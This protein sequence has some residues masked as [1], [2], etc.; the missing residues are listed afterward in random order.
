MFLQNRIL[1][2]TKNLLATSGQ[3]GPSINHHA[4]IYLNFWHH[5][6]PLRLK[7]NPVQCNYPTTIQIDSNPLKISDAIQVPCSNDRELAIFY[8]NRVEGILY[9]VSL[10]SWAGE[11]CKDLPAQETNFEWIWNQ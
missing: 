5:R 8:Y 11:H 3:G 1:A 6:T 2:K 7:V 10:G 4:P 9:V